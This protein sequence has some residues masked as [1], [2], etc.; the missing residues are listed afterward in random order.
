MYNFDYVG[1]SDVEN[2][3]TVHLLYYSLKMFPNYLF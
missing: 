1:D 3:I 2:Y